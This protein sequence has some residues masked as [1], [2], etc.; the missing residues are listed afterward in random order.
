MNR[1]SLLASVAAV[2]LTAFMTPC[3]ASAQSAT[4]IN[5]SGGSW[6]TAA[7]WQ[8]GILPDAATDA[9]INADGSYSVSVAGNNPLSRA[10]DVFLGTTSSD[11][12]QK[13]AVSSATQN[14]TLFF[15]NMTI[16]SRGVFEYGNNSFM[17]GTGLVIVAD[18]GVINRNN[19]GSQGSFHAHD[20][21]VQQGGKWTIDTGTSQTIGNQTKTVVH[22]IDG[23]IDGD[24]AMEFN[25]N[26]SVTW[27]RGSGRIAVSKLALNDWNG[28]LW[29]GGTLTIDS[30]IVLTNANNANLTLT[31]GAAITVNGPYWQNKSG[32]FLRLFEGGTAATVT[33][34]NAICLVSD[35]A[36]SN[37]RIG[38]FKQNGGTGSLTLAGSG[39]LDICQKLS[40]WSI[41]VLSHLVPLNLQRDTRLWTTIENPAFMHPEG[42]FTLNV[43]GSTLLVDTNF[44]LRMHRGANSK[45]FVTNNAVLALRS[46]VFEGNGTATDYNLDVGSGSK[47]TLAILGGGTSVLRRSA[48]TS[49]ANYPLTARLGANAVVD[50]SAGSILSLRDCRLAVAMTTP[51]SWGWKIRGT[52]ELQPDSFMEAM[53]TDLG[54]SIDVNNVGFGIRELRLAAPSG[55]TAAT[56]SLWNADAADNDGDSATDAALYVKTLDLS[57]LPAG[58]VVSLGAGSGVTA[59]AQRVYYAKLVGGTAAQLDARFV[60]LAPTATLIAIR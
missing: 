1:K 58:A 43:S 18:G 36:G 28:N 6:N 31:N 9:A 51:A 13:I 4:W 50:P 3:P 46:G 8:D 30:S 14:S 44:V 2:A 57:G 20:I 55:T 40:D 17:M 12:L 16:G 49:P 35:T 23:E 10:K 24:G 19:G 52:I 56:V 59:G 39:T 37:I 47:G 32:F 25:N 7:N 27:L 53:S 21:W 41:N 11:G 15:D 42:N 5:A 45:L 33:G 29:L 48:S 54:R 38:G 22:V 26:G 60:A 34:T